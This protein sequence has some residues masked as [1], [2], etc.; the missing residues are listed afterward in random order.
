M[1]VHVYEAR[2]RVGGRIFTAILEGNAIDL[3]GHNI[4]DGG[5]AKNIYRLVDELHLTL[6]KNTINFQ[7]DYFTGE[8]LI[9]D[10]LL[11]TGIFDPETLQVQ[12]AEI[13]KQSR[14]MREVLNTFLKDD[15]FFY[16]ALSVRLAAYEGGSIDHLSSSYAKTLYYMLLKGLPHAHQHPGETQPTIDLM[17]IQG[18]NALLPEALAQTLSEKVHLNMPLALVTRGS[19]GSYTLTF[20]NGQCVQTDILVLAMPCSVYCDITFESEILP[21][22]TLDAI[23]S[24]PYGTNAKLL[25]PFP[26]PPLTTK[27]C[28]INDRVVSFFNAKRDILTLYYTGEASRFSSDTILETYQQER[29]MLEAAFGGSIPPLSTPMVAQDRSFVAYEGP[30]GHSWSN[31]PYAKGSYPYIAPGRET[32]LG[33]MQKE[34]AEIVKTLFAPIN[35]TL[36]FAG[37]HTSIVLE[38]PGTMEA[39]C[40]SGERT[41]RMIQ[42]ASF[43]TRLD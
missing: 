26:Q 20:K 5:T 30:V 24:I 17:S 6:Q 11:H 40:E 19:N 37:E 14:N 4:S 25:V 34:G 35:H 33:S 16:K 10:H 31:D 28:L 39:A 36:Y 29:P 43:K 32:L 8:T 42:Q 22:T 21:K 13:A 27:R 7:Y 1:D 41:A 2:P 9:P 12:L 38:A 23:K 18:G 15:D 3:G